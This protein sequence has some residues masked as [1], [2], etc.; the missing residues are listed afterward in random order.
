MQNM[1][2]V[3]IK[4]HNQRQTVEKTKSTQFD[5][6]KDFGTSQESTVPTSLILR[7]LKKD[8]ETRQNLKDIEVFQYVCKMCR[9]NKSYCESS[10]QTAENI[11]KHELYSK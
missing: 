3:T 6:E 11:D 10:T 1:Q 9:K 4:Q 8:T 2:N 5:F 7:V